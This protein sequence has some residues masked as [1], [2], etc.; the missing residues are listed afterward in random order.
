MTRLR[1]AIPATAFGLAAAMSAPAW[2]DAARS[3]DAARALGE[4]I[5]AEIAA[6]HDRALS[7]AEPSRALATSAGDAAVD[8]DVYR[9][10]R[11]TAA[12]FGSRVILAIAI[13]DALADPAT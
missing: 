10:G 3:G 11:L 2:T 1:P 7:E 5:A 6:A 9:D 12:A 8:G 13:R 4:S